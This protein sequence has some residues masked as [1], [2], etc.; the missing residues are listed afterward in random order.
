MPF[1]RAINES[2]QVAGESHRPGGQGVKMTS[3]ACLWENGSIIELG[4]L[5]NEDQFRSAEAY[6]INNFRQVVGESWFG[7]TEEDDINFAFLWEEGEMINLGSLSGVG[8]SR[9]FAINDLG[10]VV[11][12]S[13]TGEATHAFIWQ[14]GQ[15][16]DLNDLIPVDSGWVR[17]WNS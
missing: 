17:L 10:Q 11:G 9:A 7:D 1:E 13:Y 12:R 5:G 4:T 15:M 8:G 6:D 2:G 3:T 14:D 16:Y